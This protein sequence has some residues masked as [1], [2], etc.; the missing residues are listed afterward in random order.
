MKKTFLYMISAAL[1]AASCNNAMIEDPVQYGTL[2]VSLAGEPGVEVVTKTD[3]EGLQYYN[4]ALYNTDSEGKP[5][6]AL[7]YKRSYAELE[8]DPF[9]VEA[10][11]SYCVWAE[12]CIPDAAESA[13]SGYGKPRYEGVSGA[14]LVEAG[15][16]KTAN[17]TCNVANAKV[18]VQLSDD[19]ATQEALTDVKVTISKQWTE[20]SSTITKD[21]VLEPTKPA[22]FNP[23]E[24]S[25]TYTVEAKSN[26]QDGKIITGKGTLPALVGRNHYKINVIAESNN[27]QLTLKVNTDVNVEFGGNI[28]VGFNP[29]DEII[30]N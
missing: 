8:A 21:V 7:F 10:G 13:N 27:G 16:A 1:L 26:L 12:S 25:T 15:R 23:R 18:S 19:A 14:V 20:N 9:V 17:V 30:N 3:P 11:K 2:S 24:S 4:V 29:Y 6:G 22:W 28:E 5:V